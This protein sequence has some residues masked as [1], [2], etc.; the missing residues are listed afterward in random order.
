MSAPT[1]GTPHRLNLSTA[2]RL[3]KNVSQSLKALAV[4]GTHTEND[5]KSQKMG[6]K[7][8]THL[9][10]SS[11]AAPSHSGRLPSTPRRSVR[12]LGRRSETGRMVSCHESLRERWGWSENPANQQPFNIF[13]NTQF[14]SVW[15]VRGKGLSQS[16]QVVEVV[17]GGQVLLGGHTQC[18]RAQ[19][20]ANDTCWQQTW[21]VVLWQLIC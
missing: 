10:W 4:G 3:D 13:G 8:K 15:P 11:E 9:G 19:M 21:F 7:R 20:A 6:K 2:G 12:C 17:V 5:A 16:V 1:S 14:D 18:P